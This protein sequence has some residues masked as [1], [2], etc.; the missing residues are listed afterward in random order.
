MQNV[1]LQT[2][3]LVEGGKERETL[4]L[5]SPCYKQSQ[6]LT[7]PASQSTYQVDEILVADSPLRVAVCQG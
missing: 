5:N 3:V 1:M 2:L 7:G 4:S 6:G